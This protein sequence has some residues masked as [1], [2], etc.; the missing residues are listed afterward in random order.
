[1]LLD[2]VSGVFVIYKNVPPSFTNDRNSLSLQVSLDKVCLIT[3][4]DMRLYDS[5][6]TASLEVRVQGSGFRVQRRGRS[7]NP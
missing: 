6:P 1:M 4:M 5:G 7:P 2:I 3:R